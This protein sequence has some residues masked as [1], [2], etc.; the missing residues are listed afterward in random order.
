MISEFMGQFEYLKNSQ[1]EI[2]L[3]LSLISLIIFQ[4]EASISSNDE[5]TYKSIFE[6]ILS[7]RDV[8]ILRE[9]YLNSLV[10]HL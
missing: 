2:F 1:N 4:R 9:Q 8:S 7:R 3:N 10:N 5:S 6:H